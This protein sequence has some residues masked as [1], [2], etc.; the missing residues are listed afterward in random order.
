MLYSGPTTWIDS[1]KN[2]T[3]NESDVHITTIHNCLF[4][5]CLTN[6]GSQGDMKTCVGMMD[7]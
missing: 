2:G 7:E 1:L 3:V 6:F 4:K 5:A